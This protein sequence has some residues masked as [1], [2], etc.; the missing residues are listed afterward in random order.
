MHR[1]PSYLCRD[2]LA[3]G[4]MSEPETLR[5]EPLKPGFGAN[6]L[7]LDLTQA[8]P[9]QLR[10]VV[11]A[12]QRSGALLLRGQKLG[13]AA[14][15][16]FVRN[17]GQ[18]EGHTLAQY[19]LPGFPEIYV[20]SNKLV[21]G[22]AIGAHNDGVGWHTDYS[23]KA[24][25]VMMTMLYAVDVPPEGSDTLLA[26][27]CAAYASLTPPMQ[28]K[29]DILQL[30]HSYVHFMSTRDYGR[31]ELSQDIKDQNP[32]VLHPLVRVH[33]VNGRK[34][35]W[36]STGTVKGIIGMPPDE[37]SALI[38]E[39]VALVTEERFVYRHKWRVGDVLLWDNRA[40][41]HTGTLYDDTKYFREMHRLWV[42]GERPLS[43]ADYARVE[44]T[45]EQPIRSETSY[46]L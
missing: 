10:G 46:G 4:V 39:L 27:M 7:D 22:K 36:V 6:I 9:L 38:D 44:S 42:R 31:L 11:D 17:F 1:R 40:T 30:H 2:S 5:I 32:D 45:L 28:K 18:P 21:D 43:V 14:L 13:P 35:L 16:S 24:E 29:L 20:L 37:A 26:D 3:S 33:P 25:P 12:F 23:Y 15:L 8:T 34:A 41:L 19:T